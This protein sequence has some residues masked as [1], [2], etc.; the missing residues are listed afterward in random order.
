MESALVDDPGP[1]NQL[2]S[3][4]STDAWLLECVDS[5]L[6]IADA[7]AGSSSGGEFR[8][9]SMGDIPNCCGI[10]DPWRNIREAGLLCEC[11][12]N[13][14]RRRVLANQLTT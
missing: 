6:S 11:M 14:R 5:A 7:D 2:R 4:L 12:A 10:G 9:R 8:H 13:R 3:G 1:S